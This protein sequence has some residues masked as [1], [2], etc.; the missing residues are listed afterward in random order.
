MKVTVTRPVEMEVDAVR[1]VLPM[2]YDDE[3]MPFEYPFRK[4]DVWDVIVDMD[5]GQIRDWPGGHALELYSKVCDTGSYYLMHGNEVVA[6]IEEDYVPNELVPGEYGDY[7]DLQIDET[8][9][10]TNWKKKPKL[11][12]FF[13]SSN[14]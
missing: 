2:R 8:G 5:T 6:K 7:V 14:E 3:D 4:D 1:L 13:K 9:K 12:S 10:I 11:G